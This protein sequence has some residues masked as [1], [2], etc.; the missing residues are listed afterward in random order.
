MAKK[1]TPD[2]TQTFDDVIDEVTHTAHDEPTLEGEVNALRI[3]TRLNDYAL[4]L[5]AI[6]ERLTR[7]HTRAMRTRAMLQQLD[8]AMKDI[9]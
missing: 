8:D 9:A 1:N 7:L 2:A 3:I 4:T 5:D 6:D